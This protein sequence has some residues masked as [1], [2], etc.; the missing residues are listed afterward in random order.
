MAAAACLLA[1][2]FVPGPAAAAMRTPR[3]GLAAEMTG[4]SAPW[5]CEIP[6][7]RAGSV[8]SLRAFHRAM[9]A[10]ADGFWAA[11]FAAAGQ[12]YSPPGVTITTGGDSVCGEIT[13]TG[14]QYCPVQRT[15]AIRILKQDLRDPFRM[16]IAHSVAHEWGHHVQ[17]LIG[18]LDAQNALYWPASESA[19]SLLSHRLEMQAECLA[20]VFYS[21]ALESIDPG[22]SWEEWIEAVRGA[23]ESEIHGKPRNLASWQDRGYHGGAV[24]FCN[25]WT[26]RESK[27]R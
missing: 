24:G 27:I 7:I 22:I 26:A 8:A 9:A 11:R 2:V 1:G 19:R 6:P 4:E 12:P 18:V 5:T 23:D 13:G 14:A 16:N 3:A 17:Q 15:I 10:C 25:T 21:A 20:G